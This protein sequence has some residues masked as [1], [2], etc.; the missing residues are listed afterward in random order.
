MNFFFFAGTSASSFVFP[1]YLYCKFLSAERKTWLK[2]SV[3]SQRWPSSP[4]S[5]R[6]VPSPQDIYEI[7]AEGEV[8]EK[9]W[10]RKHLLTKFW[11]KRGN[12]SWNWCNCDFSPWGVL[13]FKCDLLW[14][15]M[16]WKAAIF[17]CFWAWNEVFWNHLFN[18]QQRCVD[19]SMYKTEM[20]QWQ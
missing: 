9:P 19:F 20:N 11:A 1:E 14:Q 13:R 2:F 5:C 3:M 12:I 7:G 8:N 6:V 4:G 16:G 17:E 10:M 15:K 18:P